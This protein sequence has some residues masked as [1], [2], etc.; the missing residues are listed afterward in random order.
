MHC[1]PLIHSASH[2][3]TENNEG[4]ESLVNPCQVLTITFFHVFRN[5][6]LMYLLQ[7]FPE[8]EIMLMASSSLYLLQFSEDGCN[9]CP[10][11]V[12]SNLPSCC[13][14]SKIIE[15]NFEI[16]SGSLFN[17][18]GGILSVSLDLHLFKGVKLRCNW[19]TAAFF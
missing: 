16:I 9:G 13:D 18:L 14:L 17:P 8:R 10:S 7:A 19:I 1:T 2:L 5:G 6:F 4:D 15:S 12:T 3:V 11:S